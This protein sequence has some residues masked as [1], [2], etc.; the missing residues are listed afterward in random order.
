[1]V[2]SSFSNAFGQRHDCSFAKIQTWNKTLKQARLMANNASPDEQIDVGY[3][4]LDLKIGYTPQ[5]ISGQVSIYCKSKTNQLKQ[6]KIDLQK[7]LKTDSVLIE[8]KNNVFTLCP[9]PT[10]QSL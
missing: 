9:W 5:Q 8:R 1:M 10:A 2:L 4:H 3:Y 6:I 7:I